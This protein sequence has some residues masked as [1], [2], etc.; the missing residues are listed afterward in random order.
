MHHEDL[1]N[2]VILH[3]N[4]ALESSQRQFNE[5]EPSYRLQ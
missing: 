3:P 4:T 1:D 5:N 2:R